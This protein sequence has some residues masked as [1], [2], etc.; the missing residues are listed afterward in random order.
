M[1]SWGLLPCA[2]LTLSDGQ[3][4]RRTASRARRAY[5]LSNVPLHT[6]SAIQALRLLSQP[7]PYSRRGMVGTDRLVGNKEVCREKASQSESTYRL[8]TAKR[9]AQLCQRLCIEIEPHQ[10]AHLSRFIALKTSLVKDT[11]FP[12]YRRLEPSYPAV[13]TVPSHVA[14]ERRSVVI[15]ADAQ[16]VVHDVRE[17]DRRGVV[18]IVLHVSLAPSDG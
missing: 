18:Q 11:T 10:A 6:P 8:A 17:I 5:S 7:L 13:S 3:R 2:T 14:D 12:S 9:K 16:P 15:R 4:H 1:G